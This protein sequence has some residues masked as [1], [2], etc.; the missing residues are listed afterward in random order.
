MSRQKNLIIAGVALVILIGG[1]FGATA[2]KKA[3][4]EKQAEQYKS[5]YMTEI[6]TKKVT[7]I[8]LPLKGVVLERKG[9]TWT[10]PAEALGVQLDQEE[11]KSVLWSLCNMRYERV[12][13]ENPKDLEPFGLSTPK[14]R[15][16]LTLEDGSKVELLGGDKTPTGYGYYGMKGGEPK[17]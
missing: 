9:E 17:V 3:Q 13:D 4:I 14:A 16:V 6:D 15:V 10:S 11:I 1:Y 12:A 2:Y 7:R 5:L 8:E